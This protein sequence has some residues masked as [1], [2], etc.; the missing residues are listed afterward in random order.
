MWIVHLDR[1]PT[2]PSFSLPKAS[3]VLSWIFFHTNSWLSI[4]L[5]AIIFGLLENSI[6]SLGLSCISSH[7]P[8]H[9]K[10]LLILRGFKIVF[11]MVLV[12][13]LLMYKTKNKTKPQSG[14]MDACKALS[15]TKVPL[16]LVVTVIMIHGNK[17][18]I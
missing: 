14:S 2:L 10:L 5:A 15:A 4:L 12:V 16:W 6:V 11:N 3:Q 13:P 9:H 8:Q 1:L 17:V 18:P 7:A